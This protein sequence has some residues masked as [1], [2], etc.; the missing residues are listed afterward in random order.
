MTGVARGRRTLTLGLLAL[1]LTGSPIIA[2]QPRTLHPGSAASVGMDSAQLQQAVNLYRDA[3]DRNQLRGAVLLVARHGTIVVHEA[4]GWKN[5]AY[6]LPMQKDTLFQMMST[7]KPIASTATLVLEQDGKLNTQDPVAKYFDSFENEKSRSITIR[8]LLSGTS[9]FRVG[10][11]FYPFDKD[12]PHPSIRKAVDKFGKEGS[13]VEMN[14]SFSYSNAAF[15]TVA[16]LVEH[17]SGMPVEDFF[18]QRIYKP[19]GM[20]D[21]LNH[22]DPAKLERMAT[23]YSAR[24]N[25]DGVVE[26]GRGYTPGDAPEWP[27]VRGSGGL[28]TTA[29]DYAKFLQMYLDKGQA[30]GGRILT[31]ESVK[32]ATTPVVRAAACPAQ[33]KPCNT[34]TPFGKAEGSYG[35]GWFVSDDG[36]FS[37][38]G[39]SANNGHFVWADP[40]RD[41]LGVALTSG[42]NDPREAFQAAVQQAVAK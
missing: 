22:S 2:Q 17:T 13:A 32:K 29:S 40:N 33:T 19:L 1:A 12:D 5:Y 10:P 15:N 31:A 21:T 38:L 42:G 35:L 3:L 8:H 36:V 24:I 34:L 9:G 16:A 27:V 28:V 39:G 26:F 41:L 23:H 14:T 18:I 6:R 4:I 37:H 20:S 7:T 11:I 25:K 30:S